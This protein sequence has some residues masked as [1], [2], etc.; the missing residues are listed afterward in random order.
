MRAGRGSDHAQQTEAEREFVDECRFL[1][2]VEGL[3]DRVLS[4]SLQIKGWQ[5]NYVSII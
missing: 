1:E 5:A 2:L 3:V 4:A